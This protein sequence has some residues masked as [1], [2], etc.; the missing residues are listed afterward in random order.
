MGTELVVGISDCK[1][2]ANPS[3]SI[4]TYALGSC[5]GVVIQDPVMKIGGLLHILLPN[6]RPGI[7]NGEN[8]YIFADTG[9]KALAMGVIRLGG[10]RDRLIAKAAGGSNM[11]SSSPILDVGKRNVT[12]ALAVLKELSI[13]V[14]ATSFGGTVGRTLFHSLSDGRTTVRLLSGSEEE[15]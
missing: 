8:P 9:I 1:M 15:L 4:V 14:K 13:P 12:S 7:G 5:V 11:L 10:Q 2:S 6:A 3:D